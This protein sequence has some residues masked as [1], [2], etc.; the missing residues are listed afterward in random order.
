MEYSSYHSKLSP[1]LKQLT[2]KD[3]K[4]QIKAS[5]DIFEL[6]KEDQEALYE[7][8]RL[9]VFIFKTSAVQPL[10]LRRV[11]LDINN[12]LFVTLKKEMAVTIKDILGF[13]LLNIADV[14]MAL[15]SLKI[16]PNIQKVLDFAGS[17]VP[18]LLI[19]HLSDEQWCGHASV[20]INYIFANYEKY[21][22]E[23]L[24]AIES[25]IYKYHNINHFT[26]LL[27][28]LKSNK[29]KNL[30][31]L[32][33]HCI[34]SFVGLKNPDYWLVLKNPLLV[35]GLQ[36]SSR[37][38]PFLQG[39]LKL[40][41][42]K[43][44][45]IYDELKL[46]IEHLISVKIP[47][48][49]D[50]IASSLSADKRTCIKLFCHFEPISKVI[51]YLKTDS[52]S[53]SIRY[54]IFLLTC[55]QL[56]QSILQYFDQYRDDALIQFS[57]NSEIPISDMATLLNNNDSRFLKLKI[58]DTQSLELI[59]LLTNFNVHTDLMLC[60]VKNQDSFSSL[61]ETLISHNINSFIAILDDLSQMPF[62]LDLLPYQSTISR[63]SQRDIIPFY[64]TNILPV[65]EPFPLKTDLILELFYHFNKLS[66]YFNSRAFEASRLVL[67]LLHDDEFHDQ[68]HFIPDVVLLELLPDLTTQ[69]L[70]RRCA[71]LPAS[72]LALYI[73]NDQS[74]LD[75]ATKYS[76]HILDPMHAYLLNKAFNPNYIPTIKQHNVILTQLPLYELMYYT[77][78]SN[79]SSLSTDLSECL[80][81]LSNLSSNH[82]TILL[83]QLKTSNP[84]ILFIIAVLHPHKLLHTSVQQ[85]QQYKQ[86]SGVSGPIGAVINGVGSYKGDANEWDYLVRVYQTL[87]SPTSDES[88]IMILSKLPVV[89][90]H[91]LEQ[92]L[93]SRIALIEDIDLYESVSNIV[94][95]KYP[96]VFM[97]LLH[98]CLA[99]EMAYLSVHKQRR[100]DET[101]ELG[102]YLK[103]LINFDG[104]NE[105]LLFFGCLQSVNIAVKQ[106]ICDSADINSHLQMLMN[107]II[108]KLNIKSPK[109]VELRRLEKKPYIAWLF[110]SSKELYLVLFMGIL[111]FFGDFV[112]QYMINTQLIRNLEK[113]MSRTWIKDTIQDQ[114]DKVKDQFEF[115]NVNLKILQNSQGVECRVSYEIDEYKLETSFVVPQYY[116]LH[117]IHIA[118][119]ERIGVTEHLFKSWLIASR[120]LISHKNG[121]LYDGIELFSRNVQ[122]HFDGQTECTICFSI[123]GVIDKTL[124]TKK[125]LTCSNKFHGGCLQRWF[126]ESKQTNC[127]LC[128]SLFRF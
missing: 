44:F 98:K 14:P 8:S 39:L 107:T 65:L 10:Q 30:D 102:Y 82:Q 128:R 115:A 74:L 7:T 17:N 42:F 56:D 37:L 9:W 71:L 4:T 52:V 92:L 63:L 99:I 110:D 108:E 69:E 60:L 97:M 16:F 36:S 15:Q 87:S 2:K 72:I 79:N 3:V 122:G 66:D 123:I 64:C 31:L 125:C 20:A 51:E 24:T 83:K 100:M 12:Y 112:R 117:P 21:L 91:C 48:I 101:L 23:Y 1:L 26:V 113:L 29:L 70:V 86:N 85:A 103:R 68:L 32:V 54:S 33:E 121:S 27:R 104:F 49:H 50:I 61:I 95:T 18:S 62:K 77:I 120:L 5:L 34:T 67:H 106:D 127:P 96:K 105:W 75:N 57:T 118:G 40:P 76:Y 6:I 11:I 109:M 111:E 114:I 35:A 88:F 28:L 45:P 78:T 73:Y 22:T 38:K 119:I 124:P 89:H 126:K 90:S 80:L 46:L 19:I 58:S 94:N 116:P 25:S 81:F 53:E 43:L 47:N 93:L 13:W 41:D 84:Y 59:K 55:S